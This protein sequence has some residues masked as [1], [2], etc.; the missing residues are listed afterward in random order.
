MIVGI[1][2][3]GRIGKQIYRILVKNGIQV[4]LIND[5]ALDIDNLFYQARYDSVYGIIGDI[6]IGT[7]TITAHGIETALSREKN[8]GSYG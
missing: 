8:P 5:P 3:F 2:G 7:N 1:N 4:G 6:F